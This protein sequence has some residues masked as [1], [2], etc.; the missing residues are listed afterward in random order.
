MH[1]RQGGDALPG[2]AADSLG[3]ILDRKQ[4]NTPGYLRTRRSGLQESRSSLDCRGL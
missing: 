3:R 1:D 4:R 2:L